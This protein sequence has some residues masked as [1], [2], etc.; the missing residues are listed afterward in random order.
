MYKYNGLKE[1]RGIRIKDKDTSE[2][3]NLSEV[4]TRETKNVERI[5]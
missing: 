1:K 5:V 3:E 2:E 4:R